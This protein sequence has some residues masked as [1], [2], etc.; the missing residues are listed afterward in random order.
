[1][2]VERGIDRHNSDY[3]NVAEK[4]RCVAGCGRIALI[5]NVLC[6]WAFVKDVRTLCDK[7][8]AELYALLENIHV[9][10][11]ESPEAMS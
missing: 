3:R 2:E 1:M 7:D 5:I 10:M 9:I 4:S 6:W 8:G 11:N